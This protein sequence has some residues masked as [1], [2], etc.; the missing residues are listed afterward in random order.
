MRINRRR[1]PRKL[2][3]VQRA[4][5][6]SARFPQP[7]HNRGI[8]RRQVVAKYPGTTSHA[9]TLDRDDVLQ[10]NRDAVKC[11]AVMSVGDF[12]LGCPRLDNGFI[13]QYR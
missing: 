5:Q 3:E 2:M 10:R 9:H 4:E 13:G 1:A 7:T 11:A 12:V 8:A 6:H